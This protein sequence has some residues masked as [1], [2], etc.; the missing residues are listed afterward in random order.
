[1]RRVVAIVVAD[2]RRRRWSRSSC[3][4]AG[5]DDGG[6]YK[7]RAIFDNAGFVIPGE[8]VKVAGVKVGTIDSLDVTRRLQGR[9]RARDH[10]P[11]LPGLPQRR[12]VH[13]RPQSLI[14]ERFV[15]CELDAGARAGH[16][17]AAAA[18]QDRGRPGQGPVP[19]AGR[20]HQ[21]AGR[22]RPDQQ[23]HAR[24]GPP[25]AVDHPQRARH[26]R[27]R[28]RRGPQRRHPARQPGAQGG[29]QGPEDPR[30]ARTT[31]CERLAVDSDTILAPLARERRH[32][33]GAIDNS[34]AVAQ[35][36]AERRDALE[37]D[38]ER[39]PAFLPELHADDGAARRARRRDDAGARPT[40][41]R[42]RPTSTG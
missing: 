29:R 13:V 10:R 7:V 27:R 3:S 41:A 31:R 25:A 9:R 19:A 36:T 42:S 18:A 26:R 20:E 5:D 11:R 16:R 1:M 34:G 35:A 14:G 24:A 17:A 12:R 37:A 33:S 15:E 28:P 30:L 32:V 6:A 4:R 38:I 39:L 22:P 40:S 21:Q 2:R 23:H 8:D